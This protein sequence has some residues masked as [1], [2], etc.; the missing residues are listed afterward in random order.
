MFEFHSAISESIVPSTVTLRP[1]SVLECGPIL[2]PY[3]LAYNNVNDF[4]VC[5]NPGKVGGM[6]CAVPPINPVFKHLVQTAIQTA[7]RET[8][9]CIIHG[10]HLK[11]ADKAP[12]EWLL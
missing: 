1:P 12:L 11:P 7:I 8:S 9:D 5:E 10:Y 6:C 2:C 3:Q 4:I